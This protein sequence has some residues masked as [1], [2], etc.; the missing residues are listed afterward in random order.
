MLGGE[1]A[2]DIVLVNTADASFYDT[3]PHPR[4]YRGLLR[5]PMRPTAYTVGEGKLTLL[6]LTWLS[7]GREIGSIPTGNWP[8]S[9]AING[10]TGQTYVSNGRAS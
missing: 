2:S 9:I 5:D 6:N 8:G 3:I 7:S 4:E 1:D 10:P